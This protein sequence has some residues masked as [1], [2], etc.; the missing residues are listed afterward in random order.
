MP[1]SLSY[2][3]HKIFRKCANFIYLERKIYKIGTG[4]LVG[5][6]GEWQR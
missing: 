3:H 6:E 2:N 1:G 4:G 5:G